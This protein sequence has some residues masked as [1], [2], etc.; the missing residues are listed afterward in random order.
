[1]EK[2]CE[3]CKTI[4][5]FSLK[6]KICKTCKKTIDKEYRN[7]NKEK[8]SKK[9]KEIYYNIKDIGQRICTYCNK[10]DDHIYFLKH[11]YICK[12]CNKK[13]QKEY[14]TKNLGKYLYL[15]IKKRTKYKNIIVDL[16]E[17]DIKEKIPK[18]MICPL[19]KI[20][21]EINNNYARGNS[22]T[23]DR[24]DPNKGYVKNN[25]Q[26]ISQKAN[27]SKSNIYIDEYEKIYLNLIKIFKGE[28]K[29]IGGGDF[30]YNIAHIKYRCKKNNIDF[31]IDK[32]YLKIIYPKKNIC[33]LCEI[34]FENGIGVKKDS[35]ISL[36][37]IYPNKGY[38]R[39]NVMFICERANRVKNNLTINEMKTLLDN[40][41]LLL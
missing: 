2:F 17:N 40:W 41:K 29:I 21:M 23:I 10:K 3:K 4:K 1:M 22:P 9:K 34:F 36:D 7:R 16:N 14:R 15:S 38:I 13:T 20:K 24:I 37:R 6:G 26:I 32:K 33:P 27:L 28:K 31:N 19:L 39:G 30:V 11:K 18:D 25:I 5:E 12:D 35:S 8:I